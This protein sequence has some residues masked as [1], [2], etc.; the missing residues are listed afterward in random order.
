MNNR[1][2]QHASAYDGNNIY[3]YDNEIILKWYPE[4]ILRSY[5]LSG[6]ILELGLGHGFAT[7]LFSSHFER[8]VV[9]DGSP[10]VIE[11]FRDK[12]AECDVEIVQTY[13][14]DFQ[15]EEKFD[16]IVMGFVL[17]HVDDPEFII[18]HYS[19]F[20]KPDGRMFVAVPN[21]EVLNRRVGF[22]AG[23][24]PDL[25][26]MSDHDRLL[27]HKRYYTVDSL[28]A[29]I[30]KSGCVVKRMEGIYLKPFTTDQ[31]Y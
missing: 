27:G 21:A 6:S 31:R 13:F 30:E 3:D 23:L 17:E 20:L 14:E 7:N 18:R 25:L 10:V 29:D 8:H 2:D 12:F 22:L 28:K 15:P 24:L 16:V 5:N 9:L 1:L 19:E 4:R 26:E 11:K